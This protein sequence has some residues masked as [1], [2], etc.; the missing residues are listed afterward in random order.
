[1]RLR[2]FMLTRHLRSRS[3]SPVSPIEPSVV[4]GFDPGLANLVNKGA[5]DNGNAPAW[6]TDEASV[7]TSWLIA[8]ADERGIDTDPNPNPGTTT[9]T[10]SREALAQWSACMSIDDWLSFTGGGSERRKRT[11]RAKRGCV[12]SR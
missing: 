6:T 2:I 11:H 8:E 12:A 7:M 9:P 10:T 5:H 3:D 4:G 1:M